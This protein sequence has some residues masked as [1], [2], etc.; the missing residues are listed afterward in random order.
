MEIIEKIERTLDAVIPF[1]ILVLST[2]QLTGI[3]EG[4]EQAMPIV[5]GA[6]ALV[7]AVFK[8]WGVVLR[9]KSGRDIL[10]D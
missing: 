3:T 9:G 6:L 4:V 2:F 1:V 8:I 5:Y 10:S 7:T